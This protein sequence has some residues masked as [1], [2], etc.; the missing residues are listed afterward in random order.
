MPLRFLAAAA[1]AA[2]GT[3]AAAHTAWFERDAPSA[4]W[5]LMFGGHAGRLV[6]A[7]STK[8]RAITAID[9]AGRQLPVRRLAKGGGLAVSVAGAPALI[10]MHY[11]NGIHTRT[12]SG[13]SVAKP[14]DAVPGAISAVNAQKYHKTIVAWSPV[15]TQPL[16][17]AFEVTP[18]EGEQPRAGRPM[19]VQVRLDGQPAAGIRVGRGEDDGQAV[20][21]AE[22]IASITP[23]TGFN[24]IWAGKRIEQR[25]PRFTQLSYEYLLAFD[26]R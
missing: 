17:Q 19:R 14:M 18:L 13:P 11:D 7:D 1:L 12:G 3:A 4:T 10:A 8:A 23:T 26:A 2:L 9:A 25:T 20:T 5:R 21:D 16:G 22:G 15:V 6:P 24:K